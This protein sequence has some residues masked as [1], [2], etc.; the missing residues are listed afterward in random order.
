MALVNFCEEA[1][2]CVNAEGVAHEPFQIAASQIEITNHACHL[3]Q[4]PWFNVGLQ[5]ATTDNLHDSCTS[6]LVADTTPIPAI[7]LATYT[8]MVFESYMCSLFRICS[9]N[10]SCK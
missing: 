10:T 9:L 2:S 8:H 3:V 1:L 7:Q 4:G 5:I 6:Q